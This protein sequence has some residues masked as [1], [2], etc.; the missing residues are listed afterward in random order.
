MV[1]E[2]ELTTGLV[3]KEA[4]FRLVAVKGRVDVPAIIRHLSRMPRRALLFMRPRYQA[5]GLPKPSSR[6][7]VATSCP[8]LS[9]VRPCFGQNCITCVALRPHSGNLTASS[10]TLERQRQ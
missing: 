6:R 10:V 1:G 3:A 4:S 7:S 8:I 9:I 5:V 2:R